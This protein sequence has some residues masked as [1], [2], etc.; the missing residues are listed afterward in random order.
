MRATVLPPPRGVGM[1]MQKSAEG[2]VG[3]DKDE[4]SEK[5]LAEGLNIQQRE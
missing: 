3:R 4:E 2:I 1:R 5:S